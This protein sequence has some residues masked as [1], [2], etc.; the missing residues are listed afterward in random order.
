MI[1]FYSYFNRPVE[2]LIFLLIAAASGFWAYTRFKKGLSVTFTLVIVL[3]TALMLLSAVILGAAADETVHLHLSWLIS[4]GLI[5]YKDFWQHHPPFLWMIL[6][7]F[8]SLMKPSVDIFSVSRILSGCMLAAN[9][10]LAWSIA[11]QV[12]GEKAHLS[13][14]LLILSSVFLTAEVLL[15]RPDI[16]MTFFLLSGIGISLKIPG[17]NIFPSFLAGV[18]LALAASFMIKQY[19]LIL[20]PVI[21]V[22]MGNKESRPLKLLLYVLGFGLGSAPLLSY[23][24]GKGILQDYIFWVFGFNPKLV[25]L[26]VAFPI[27]ILVL[28]GWG[29][30]LLIKKF[31]SLHAE[32]A[33]ILF[34]AFCLSTISSLTTTASV[35][36]ATYLATWFFISAIVAS[37]CN[38]QEVLNKIPSLCKRAVLYGL[39]CSFFLAFSIDRFWQFKEPDYNTDKKAVAQLMKYCD[40]EACFCFSPAHPV[41]SHDATRLYSFWPYAFSDWSPDVYND[42]ISRPIVAAVMSLRPP[43]IPHRYFKQDFIIDLFQKRLISAADYKKIIPFLKENYTVQ[44]IGADSYYLRNDKIK[45]TP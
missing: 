19:T 36:K 30:Y 45:Q 29:A 21:A 27:G 10:F 44:Q 22:Y 6:S 17:R 28:G 37:G 11:K 41:F 20:L 15:L 38:I 39:I 34:I 24:L 32:S 31:R 3:N 1:S 9:M 2:A 42:M 25:V 43:V 4:Q 8:I 13:V 18:A 35:G 5:P 23:L 16:F 26:S 14:F 7:P 12:W 40:G 33:L